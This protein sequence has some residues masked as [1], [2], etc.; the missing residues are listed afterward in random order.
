[1]LD[2][3]GLPVLDKTRLIGGCLRL[4]VSVDAA[5]LRGEVE[6]LPAPLWWDGT[7]GRVNVHRAAQAVFLRGYAPVEVD[8]PIEDRPPLAQLPYAKSLITEVIGTQPLRC[9]LARLP[10]GAVITPHIDLAPYF[11]KALR[12]HVPVITSE[13]VWMYSAGLSYRMKPGEAWMLN[14]SDLHGVWNTSA[15]QARI[16]LICDFVPTPALLELMTHGERNLG[17]DEPAVRERMAAGA[18]AR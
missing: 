17:I 9:L 6:A 18:Q 8:R 5:R 10:A 11:S 4:P 2:L 13:Q 15:D 12:V 14:N 16:H 1:M 7:G 3:P